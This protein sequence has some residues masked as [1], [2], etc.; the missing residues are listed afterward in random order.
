M[1]APL[2]HNEMERLE[3]LRRY[4]ILDTL[5]EQIFDDLVLLAAQICQTPIALVSL[6]DSDCQWFKSK[7]GSTAT[8]TSREIAF[9]A[10]AILGPEPF[11]VRD[12][13]VDERFVDNPL[14]TSDPRIRFY[15]GAPLVTGEGH[16]LGTLCVLDRAPRELS[17]DQSDALRALSRQVMMQIEARHQAARLAQVNEQLSEEIKE[18]SRAE[19]ALRESEMFALSIINSLTANICVLDREGKI[20]AVNRAW[21]RFARENGDPNLQNCCVG[22]DYLGTMFLGGD[23]PP[24][25]ADPTEGIKAVLQGTLPEFSLE[26]PCH[27]PDE[28]R[29]FVLTASPLANP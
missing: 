26:Y 11:I 10:H 7:F 20:I 13:M 17:S 14:V 19:D 21:E 18:R 4:E 29:W 28:R 8:E 22:T 23:Q 27:S 15:A 3:A 12:A 25:P 6:I 5:P 1:K 9:C 2:P 24:R 16:A